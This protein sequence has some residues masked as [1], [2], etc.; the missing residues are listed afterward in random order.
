MKTLKI[1]LCASLIVFLFT[2]CEK[3]A[4]FPLPDMPVANTLPPLQ[5]D[6]YNTSCFADGETL[7]AYDP[8]SPNFETYN[9][10]I[11]IVEWRAGDQLIANGT[12]LDCVCGIKVQV[13]VKNIVTGQ[14]GQKEYRVVGCQSSKTAGRRKDHRARDLEGESLCYGNLTS[15]LLP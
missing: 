5:I 7:I 4:I 15:T 6:I 12:Q 10:D 3:P 14:T 11:Y 8:E 13:L 2:A 9:A 1:S